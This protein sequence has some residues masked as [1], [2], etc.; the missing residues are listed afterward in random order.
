MTSLMGT[1]QNGYFEV[2]KLLLEQKGIDINAENKYGKTAILLA[3]KN[4]RTETCEILK[5]HEGIV[6]DVFA[7][8]KE[9]NSSIFQ[10]DRYGYAPHRFGFGNTG[11]GNFVG[12]NSFNNSGSNNNNNA[13]PRFGFG[14][15]AFGNG[16][17]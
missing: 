13:P 4:N 9:K 14:N 11:F 1:S 10:T 3:S 2:V 15:T 6:Y 12:N 8:A 17:K 16:W 7:I 5:T